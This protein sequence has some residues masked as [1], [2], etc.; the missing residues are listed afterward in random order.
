[1]MHPLLRRFQLCRHVRLTLPRAGLQAICAAPERQPYS[2]QLFCSESSFLS[3]PEAVGTAKDIGQRNG[4]PAITINHGGNHRSILKNGQHHSTGVTR[5]RAGGKKKLGFEAAGSRPERWSTRKTSATDTKNRRKSLGAIQ[6]RR[7]QLE[8]SAAKRRKSMPPISLGSHVAHSQSSA[9]DSTTFAAPKSRL[10]S[11]VLQQATTLLQQQ[12]E[13]SVSPTSRENPIESDAILD[14]EHQMRAESFAPQIFSP[15]K[16]TP[17][18]GTIGRMPRDDAIVAKVRGNMGDLI[19]K[20]IRKRNRDLTLLRSHGQHLLP[21]QGSHS[22]PKGTTGA[23][24]SI[25]D[26]AYVVVCLQR[27][28]QVTPHSVSYDCQIHEVAAKLER[29]IPSVL[30]G[31]HSEVLEAIFQPKTDEYLKLSSGLMLKIYEPLHY[32]LEKAA[33]GSACKPRWF[34]LSTQLM[35]VVQGN[36]RG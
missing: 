13:S 25:Q 12:K 10:L 22:S 28:N 2:R 30:R 4:N 1:M 26:R 36:H 8:A 32:V 6:K 18:S 35:E 24:E 9:D 17:G 5:V 19:R 27:R 33:A 23:V 21:Q 7:S 15:S 31:K 20:A 3:V 34:L 16:P 14:T 29:S 11:D